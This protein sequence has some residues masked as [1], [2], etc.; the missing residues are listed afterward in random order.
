MKL[1]ETVGVSRRFARSARVDA[2]VGKAEALDGYVLQPSVRQAFITLAQS[3]K[4]V[5]Q[6]AFTWTGPYGGGK[7]SAPNL[8][9]ADAPHA[10]NIST[11]LPVTG[12]APL[13]PASAPASPVSSPASAASAPVSLKSQIEMLER[14]GALPPL[15]RSASI[16]GPDANGNGVRD[17]IEAYVNSL[18]LSPVQKRAVMQD[19]RAT[20]NTLTVDLTDKA[21]LQKAGDALMASSKCLGDSFVPDAEGPS[22]LSGKIEAMTANTRE[23]SRQYMAYN[24]ARSGSATSMPSYDTCEK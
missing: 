12:S 19:A 20:Q 3:F 24:A 9:P 6:G 5:R 23:R 16:V 18:P 15:D 8:V 4:Q 14:S 2:D 11:A 13:A 22:F 1:A 10:V 7:S 17:D 21:A